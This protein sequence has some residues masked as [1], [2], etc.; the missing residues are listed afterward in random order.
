[1]ANADQLL[2]WGKILTTST[3]YYIAV[4][5]DFKGHYGFPHKK[6]YYRYAIHWLSKD[7]FEF[8]ELPTLDEFNKTNANQFN[9]LPFTGNPQTVLLNVQPEGEEKKPEQAEPVDS[10]EEEV[11]KIEPKNYTEEDRLAY[12]VGAIEQECQLAPLGAFKMITCH[13]IRY[14]DS[15]RPVSPYNFGLHQFVHFRYPQS[16][17]AKKK[18]GTPAFIQKA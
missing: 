8:Q 2:F 15:F 4:A 9:N 10:D 13:E 3:P 18:I 11:V 5:I 16:S 6:F 7:N 17:E 1:M 14:N 12:T